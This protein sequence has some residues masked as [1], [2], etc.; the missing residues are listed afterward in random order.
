MQA[1]VM[2]NSSLIPGYALEM[3]DQ[4]PEKTYLRIGDDSIIGARFIFESSPGEVSVGNRVLLAGGLVIC[5]TRISIG[6][7]VIIEAGG[8]LYDHS[9]HALDYRERQKDIKGV[10]ADHRNANKFVASKDWSAVSAKPISIG[11]QAWIGAQVVILK[12]V[13]I[14]EGAVV[15]PYSVVSSDVRAWTTV[16]GNPAVAV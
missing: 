12:G 4:I 3:R 7:D 9:S 15:R 16:A 11:N 14:G 5:R 6:D 1:L 10:V 8:Y 2:G 13:T